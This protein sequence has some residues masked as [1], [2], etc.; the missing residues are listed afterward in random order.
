MGFH[1]SREADAKSGTTTRLDSTRLGRMDGFP[2]RLRFLL[3]TRRV[4]GEFRLACTALSFSGEDE[5]TGGPN[6]NTEKHL[7][8]D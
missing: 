7:S 8:V 6:K 2:F 5:S 3:Q 1:V 4:F